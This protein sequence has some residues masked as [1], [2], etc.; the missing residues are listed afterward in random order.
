MQVPPEEAAPC[1]NYP[2]VGVIQAQPARECRAVGTLAGRKVSIPSR[3][4]MSGVQYMDDDIWS[5]NYRP[6]ARGAKDKIRDFTFLLRSSDLRPIESEADRNSYLFYQLNPRKERESNWLAVNVV[7]EGHKFNAAHPFQGL[8]KA[9][10]ARGKEQGA[11]VRQGMLTKHQVLNDGRWPGEFFRYMDVY[12]S[13]DRRTVIKCEDVKATDGTE[14]YWC[15]QSF[16]DRRNDLVYRARYN[17]RNLVQRWKEIETASVG[18]LDK[19][20]SE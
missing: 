16:L 11:S 13:D 3:Y 14:F 6:V 9:V 8:L 15:E 1:V 5:P 7:D 12:I 20:T 17:G 18:L 10:L 19:L 4:I 2:A